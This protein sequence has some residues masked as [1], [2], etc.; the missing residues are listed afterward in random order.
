MNLFHEP[1]VLR[2]TLRSIRATPLYGRFSAVRGDL[3]HACDCAGHRN[4]RA[5]WIETTQILKAVCSLGESADPTVNQSGRRSTI[6]TEPTV[7][8]VFSI[9]SGSDLSLMI[10]PV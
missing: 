6:R 8:N 7:A 9:N 4:R 2:T 3:Q 1:T 5:G 10:R